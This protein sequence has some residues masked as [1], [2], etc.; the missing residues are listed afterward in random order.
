MRISELARR[1][2]VTVPTIKYYLRVGLLTAGRTTAHNQA[3]YDDSH[4]RELRLVHVFVD[5]G[6]L[7]VMA[8][9]D[10]LAAID[11]SG[12]SPEHLLAAVDAAWA[13]PRRRGPGGESRDNVRP[14]IAA[15]AESRGWRVPRDGRAVRRLADAC[16]AAQTLDMKELCAALDSYA[17]AAEHMAECD[18]AVTEA[19]ARRLG[20]GTSRQ[21]TVLEAVIAAVVLGDAVLGALHSM[22]REDGLARLLAE[23]TATPPD[24]DRSGWDGRSGWDEGPYRFT[25]TRASTSDR[26][27]GTAGPPIPKEVP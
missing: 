27:G 13:A 22:A 17:R 18:I 3:V 24:D 7:S 11:E 2:G 6:G 12:T 15:L 23:W 25:A 4:L 19:L 8:T 21:R 26:R 20:P 14:V 5:I 16:A 9:R 1:S 10:L